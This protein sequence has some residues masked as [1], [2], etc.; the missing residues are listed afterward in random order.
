MCAR[1]SLPS[2]MRLP[3]GGGCTS[4]A[5]RSKQ[6]RLVIRLRYRGY[7]PAD[8]PS[9]ENLAMIA[10]QR[11]F[12]SIIHNPYHVPG[13][14]SIAFVNPPCVCDRGD[15]SCSNKGKFDDDDVLRWFLLEKAPTGHNIHPWAHNFVLLIK[16]N[17]NFVPRILYN[18]LLTYG[19]NLPPSLY[20][21]GLYL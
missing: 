12:R 9:F 3:R 11:L 2:C 7:L 14:L 20:H 21:M 5:D 15:S 1:P 17:N 8:H 13:L 4:T 10:D 6:E 16:D 18:E 19:V